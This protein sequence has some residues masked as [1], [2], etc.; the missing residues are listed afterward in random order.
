M[1]ELFIIPCQMD[2]GAKMYRILCRST[3]L[4][5]LRALTLG[6]TQAIDAVQVWWAEQIIGN[7]LCD[8]HSCLQKPMTIG[9][10]E[11]S[12]F[13]TGVGFLP[14]KAQ[15]ACCVKEDQTKRL[16]WW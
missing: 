13:C 15:S 10:I 3:I 14:Q 11:I 4:C 12:V 6:E 16:K 2:T 8:N 5:M 9:F 7:Y 1:N